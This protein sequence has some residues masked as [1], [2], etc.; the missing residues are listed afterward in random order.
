MSDFETKVKWVKAYRADN[1]V[2]LKEAL[3]AY[4]QHCRAGWVPRKEF[5]RQM[6]HE[7]FQMIGY[8]SMMLSGMALVEH[9]WLASLAAFL[10]GHFSLHKSNLLSE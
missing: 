7:V 2:S 3:N 9:N 10:I 8:L 1:G 4:E 6:G 5:F